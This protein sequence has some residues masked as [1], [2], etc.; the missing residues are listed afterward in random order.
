MASPKEARP[1]KQAVLSFLP[2]PQLRFDL[3]TSTNSLFPHGAARP[4]RK[5]GRPRA[6]VPIFTSS[7]LAVAAPRPSAVTPKRKNHDWVG[8]GKLAV[9]HDAV[10]RTPN[11]YIAVRALQAIK[12]PLTKLQPFKDL[13]AP[14][15]RFWY[16]TEE[17]SNSILR[18]ERGRPQLK[19]KLQMI[20]D[21]TLP[22]E[23]RK[24]GNGRVPSHLRQPEATGRIL[25]ELSRLR[26]EGVALNSNSLQRTFVQEI[27]ECCPDELKE[28]T[29]SRAWIRDFC[30][31]VANLRWRRTTTCG[32][33]LPED[34]ELQLQFLSKKLCWLFVTFADKD[35]RYV[36][37]YDHTAIE[38]IPGCRQTYVPSGA[39]EVKANGWNDKRQY[40]CVVGVTAAGECLPL[41]VSRP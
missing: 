32:Q 31:N 22:A 19:P 25:A 33:K 39:H 11:F 18:D 28:M 7:G 17:D 2:A 12:D 26:V 40:T 37:N 13:A 8:E 23:A 27:L 35:P 36:L 14:T 15:I 20:L 4:K 5:P 38:L 3:H 1:A 34:W 21:G 30:R 10:L 29:I 6:G 16:Q 24:A 41:Q 9:I